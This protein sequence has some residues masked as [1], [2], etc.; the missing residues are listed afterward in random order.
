MVNLTSPTCSASGD[1]QKATQGADGEQEYFRHIEIGVRQEAELQF[2]DALKSY[3]S[4]LA[5]PV[6]ELSTYY[7][8]L[9]IGRVEYK[10]GRYRD[11]VAT[12]ESYL[13]SI[14]VDI[15]VHTDKALPPPGY[16]L[17]GFSREGFQGL[18]LDKSEAESLL[19]AAKA[20][21]RPRPHQ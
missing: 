2:I 13:R 18:L 16:R 17:W 9:D 1:G 7:V 5:T 14:A 11:S 20:R 4:A 21:L 12:L 6:F 10:M 15:D 3:R 19:R 8:L